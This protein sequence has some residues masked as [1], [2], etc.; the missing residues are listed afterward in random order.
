MHFRLL[1]ICKLTNT[2]TTLKNDRDLV[3]YTIYTFE[4][5]EYDKNSV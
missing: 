5:S 1:L 2:N 4:Y 3:H